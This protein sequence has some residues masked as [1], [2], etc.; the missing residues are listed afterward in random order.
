MKKNYRLTFLLITLLLSLSVCAQTPFKKPEVKSIIKRVADW[1][2]DHQK[3]VKYGE[4]NWTN[5]T[6]YIGMLKWA[7]MA[8]EED[9]DSSYYKW[10]LRIGSRNY[11]QVEKRMYHADDIA[12]AQI[13]IDLYRKYKKDAMINPTIARTEWVLKHPSKGSFELDYNKP[14]TLERW[15]WCD[16]LF[17]A[18]PVYA[19]LYRITGNKKYIKF[20]NKEYKATYNYLFDKEENL[21]FR[22]WHYF[23]QKE[24]NGKKIFWGRGNGWVL[25][26]LA[27]ILQE[28]PKK[29]KNRKY[30]E[31]LYIRL[32]T[33]VAEFQNNDGF[34]H[35]SLLDPVSYPSPETSCTA[36]NVYAMAYGVN[37]GILDK[38]VFLPVIIKGWEALVS[39]VNDDGKLGY[40]QPVGADPKKVT[41]EMTEVF[42]V[43]AFILAGTQI[44]RMA[45]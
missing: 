20:L 35:A 16:A 40:V 44:Y 2:I 7:K 11:W 36:F 13:Y 8:E 43:G 37:E 15:T 4:L 23:T 5:A 10:L 32:S 28:L 30:Y 25:G 1:Q 12:I 39:S 22:D 19:K 3:E 45:E 34:W 17:M 24:E 21:F 27:E 33:R 38:K 6:L 9:K 18:P 41:R 26:G 29:D 31:E 14:E 42:G